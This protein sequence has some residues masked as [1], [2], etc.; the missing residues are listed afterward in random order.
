[1]RARQPEHPCIRVRFAFQSEA[2]PATDRIRPQQLADV[3]LVGARGYRKNIA[4]G[5]DRARA[6]LAG[7]N[8]PFHSG[9]PSGKRSRVDTSTRCMPLM[10]KKFLNMKK[11]RLLTASNARRAMLRQP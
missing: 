3:G 1:M 6:Q 2:D 8:G 7:N 4:A 9:S 11:S 5:D 10:R